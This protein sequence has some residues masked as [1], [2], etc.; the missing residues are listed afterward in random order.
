MEAMT[1][2][3]IAG[4][5]TPLKIATKTLDDP[6][7]GTASNYE[8]MIRY[9]IKECEQ[10]RTPKPLGYGRWCQDMKAND[11][12]EYIAP[13]E[14]GQKAPQQLELAKDLKKFLARDMTQSFEYHLSKANAGTGLNLLRMAS[15]FDHRHKELS[16]LSKAEKEAVHK[17]VWEYCGSIYK[18]ITGWDKKAASTKSLAAPASSSSAPTDPYD[19]EIQNM[20]KQNAEAKRKREGNEYTLE[21]YYRHFRL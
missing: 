9:V 11:S 16:W 6:K 2:Q 12:H 18:T 3:H 17:D 10:D 15:Y 5:F 7:N 21:I 19:I 4:V 20:V 1:C 13:E 14:L 8:P